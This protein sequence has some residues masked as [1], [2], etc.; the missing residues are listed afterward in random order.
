MAD[1]DK[2]SIKEDD[3]GIDGIVDFLFEAGILAKTQRTAFALLGSGEQSVAEHINR[4]CYIGYCLAEMVGD[5][6]T[7]KVVQLCLFHDISESRISDLN[8][9]HQKYTERNEHRAHSDIIESLPFGIRTKVLIDEYEERKSKESML[10]KDAD[11]LELLLSVK[12]QQDI[13]NKQA[14]SW[15]PVIV[16][17]LKTDEG[18]MLAERILEISFDNWWFA[19]KEDEWWVSRNKDK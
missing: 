2:N 18:R 6:D 19:D 1:M 17:R 10:A 12:E 7:G 3:M 8:Y 14:L 9:V 15:I 16:K 13:G 4:T 11:I 5:V